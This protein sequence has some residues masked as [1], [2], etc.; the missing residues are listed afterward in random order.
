MPKQP[1]SEA[2]AEHGRS[3]GQKLPAK[4]KSA[5]GLENGHAGTAAAEVNPK[6]DLAVDV[7]ERDMPER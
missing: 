6:P 4:A 3:S 2:A 7:R 1:R 5:Q